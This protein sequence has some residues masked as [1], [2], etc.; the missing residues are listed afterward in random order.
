MTLFWDLNSNLLVEHVITVFMMFWSKEKV[1]P[2]MAT[3]FTGAKIGL[4]DVICV[5]STCHKQIEH[6]LTY[7]SSISIYIS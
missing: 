2:G 3:L 6:E 1:I 5:K 7:V 4:E